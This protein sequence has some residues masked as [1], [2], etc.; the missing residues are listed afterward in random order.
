MPAIDRS[1]ILRA[2]AA[3]CAVLFLA[4]PAVAQQPLAAAPPKPEFLSRYDFHLSA[5]ALR[6]DDPR[7]SWDAHFG[8][9]LDALDYVAGRTSAVIDYEVVLG[10]QL[11]IF[12]PN[13]GSYTLEVSTSYRIR[14]T[15][16]AAIFHHVSRHLSDRPKTIPIAWNVLGVRVLR[17]ADIGRATIDMDG[18]IGR[19]TEHSFVD[20][21]WAGNGDVVVRRLV[22]PR[23]ALF[24]HGAGHLMGVDSAIIGPRGTQ[25]GG[26]V[27]G[28]VRLIGETGSAELF[29]GFERRFDASP[30]D[31]Q[32]QRWFMVGFRLLS[33]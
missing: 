33:K 14:R 30:I 3:A 22:A 21:R 19:V 1:L 13:Q 16:L 4:S 8:G 11:R 31:F 9:D 25:A 12:D 24:A 27:E 20:Y 29:A 2:A 17:H 23:A 32:P 10:N 7:F 26:L 6:I 28:G 5:A 18:D 15:E